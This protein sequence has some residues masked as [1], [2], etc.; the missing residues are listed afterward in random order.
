MMGK[1]RKGGG[2]FAVCLILVPEH[3]IIIISEVFAK[4]GKTSFIARFVTSSSYF[5]RHHHRWHSAKR[6]PAMK[7]PSYSAD[8]RS[9]GVKEIASLI[10]TDN[11]GFITSIVIVPPLVLSSLRV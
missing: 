5:P 2:L 3:I 4:T 6:L 11:S 1:K 7:R 9:P 10:P 8:L